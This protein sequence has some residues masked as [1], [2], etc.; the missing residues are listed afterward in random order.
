MTGKPIQQTFRLL[1]IHG[2]KDPGEQL[3]DWGFN[4]TSLEGITVIH[5]TYGHGVV[6]FVDEEA[7]SKAKVITGWKYFD[8]CALE[9]AQ[10]EDLVSTNE[11]YFGD[12]EITIS[13]GD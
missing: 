12:W 6:H 9:I 2:R 8:N 11:G 5:F 3:E 7:V 13:E 4:G 1:F 10:F